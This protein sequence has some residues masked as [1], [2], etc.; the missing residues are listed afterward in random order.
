MILAK[1]H[2][3]KNSQNQAHC[4]LQMAERCLRLALASDADHA[5][6]LVNLGILKMQQR[7]ADE[8]RALFSAAARKGPHLYEAHFNYALL[9]HEV[10]N[11]WEI[12]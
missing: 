9:L 11:F 8:A 3:L 7:H 5:E 2:F 4:D 10:E 1:I 6:S 12:F